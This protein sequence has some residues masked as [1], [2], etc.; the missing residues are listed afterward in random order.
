[1]TTSTNSDNDYTQLCHMRL[2]H[3]G[4]KSLQALTKKSL[5]KGA[6]TCNLKFYKHCVI[7]MKTKMRF[8]TATHCTERILDYFHTDV[9]DL[10]KWHLLEVAITLYLL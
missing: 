5:M 1:V 3:T 6:N 4:D 10:P 2:G 7:G 9:W 8:R